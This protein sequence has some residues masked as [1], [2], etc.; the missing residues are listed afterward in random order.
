M[1]SLHL[2]TSPALSSSIRWTGCHSCSRSRLGRLCAAV[3]GGPRDLLGVDQR[4]LDR[5]RVDA[6]DGAGIEDHREGAPLEVELGERLLGLRMEA[7]EGLSVGR[8]RA[9]SQF[10]SS[11]GQS[12]GRTQRAGGAR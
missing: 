9:R 4:V 11:S 6:A 7:G 8:S 3:H 2:S 1:D 5:G 12:F 10:G